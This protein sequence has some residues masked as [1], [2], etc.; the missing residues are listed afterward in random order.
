MRLPTRLAGNRPCLI[1]SRIFCCEI[2]VRAE[3]SAIDQAA[4]WLIADKASTGL[5]SIFARCSSNVLIDAPA[6]LLSG[7]KLFQ[8][9]SILWVK[10]IINNIIYNRLYVFIYLLHEPKCQENKTTSRGAVTSLRYSLNAT[11]R[12]ERL[13][14][15]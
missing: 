3:N 9:L 13:P 4:F 12:M 6:M 1:S 2:P 11:K 7:S 10:M 5:P 8:V 15:V 14:F